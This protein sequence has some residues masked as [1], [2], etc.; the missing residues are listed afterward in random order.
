MFLLTIS[1]SCSK[2]NEQYK[3]GNS[4]FKDS[5]EFIDYGRY[6]NMAMDYISTHTT[7]T[8]SYSQIMEELPGL[9]TDFI[10]YHVSDPNS[11]LYDPTMI[12]DSIFNQTKQHVA[13]Y[14]D[15]GSIMDTIQFEN[16]L[17]SN[18]LSEFIRKIKAASVDRSS[19]DTTE[20]KEILDAKIDTIVN[21]FTGD[22]REFLL[23]ELS[24]AKYSVCYWTKQELL[25]SSSF[26]YSGCKSWG[27][28]I[29]NSDISGGIAGAITGGIGGAIGG[30][31]LP[32]PG[33]ITGAIGGAVMG[34]FWG[35]VSGSAVAAVASFWGFKKK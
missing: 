19:W 31:V 17:K 25:G 20:M 16:F 1:T 22:E 6:H 18:D 23:M 13:Y 35:A 29:A 33:T 12:K 24:I 27:N 7:S 8:E 3:K 26:W 2:T 32:G 9:L 5:Y 21:D 11:P 15:L 28:N 4:I 14:N 10:Y 34:G 30:S